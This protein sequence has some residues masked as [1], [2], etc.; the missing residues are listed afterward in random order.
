MSRALS[1]LDFELTV[2]DDRPNLPTLEANDAAHHR[3]VISYDNVAAE[4]PRARTSTWW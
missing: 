2:L 4:I 1:L 3:R